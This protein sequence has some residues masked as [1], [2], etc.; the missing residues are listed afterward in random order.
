[1]ILGAVSFGIS[2]VVLLVWP[3]WFAKYIGVIQHNQSQ[4]EIE[5]W[6]FQLLGVV[7]LALSIHMSSTSRHVPDEVFR[8]AAVVMILISSGLSYLTFIAPGFKTDGRWVFVSIGGLFAFLYAVTLP[9]KS[10]G[11]QEE[12][13][14]AQ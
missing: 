3:A 10:I 5:H 8:R 13:V 2:A 12:V 1:M 6:T 7:L 9:I 14:D 11:I 4:S